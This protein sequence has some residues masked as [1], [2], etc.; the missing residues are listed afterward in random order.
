LSLHPINAHSIEDTVFLYRHSIFVS[1]QEG[2]VPLG[3]VVLQADL[4]LDSLGELAFLFL[5]GVGQE[6]LD[7]LSDVGDRNFAVP[8][9]AHHCRTLG[10]MYLIVNEGYAR[11]SSYWGG[12]VINCVVMFPREFASHKPYFVL[13]QPSF[14]TA[15]SATLTEYPNFAQQQQHHQHRLNSQQQCRR[16]S[17]PTKLRSSTSE[18][19]AERSAPHPP[20]LPKSDPSVSPPRRSA[21]ILQR[22]YRVAPPSFPIERA[23][24]L[25]FPLIFRMVC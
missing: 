10:L 23:I 9:S 11:P 12:R 5:G 24:P 18:Q 6:V 17:I 2:N 7:I 19:P 13:G 25:S 15:F 8:Q 22:Y 3:V 14:G 16:N 1:T 4:Q 20:S 21:K